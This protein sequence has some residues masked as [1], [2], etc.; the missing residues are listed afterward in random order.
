MSE[1][2]KERLR[3]AVSRRLYHVERVVRL[4]TKKVDINIAD[5]G[6]LVLLSLQKAMREI[7]ELFKFT[8]LQCGEIVLTG[9]AK[10]DRYIAAEFQPVEK[11]KT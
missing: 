10:E 1:E 7:D 4:L 3:D 5:E 8:S 2:Q 6:E 11:Q 9:I